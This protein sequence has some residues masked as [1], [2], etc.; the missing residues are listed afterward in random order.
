MGLKRYGGPPA[1]VAQAD[2]PG[3]DLPDACREG[4]CS[5]SGDSAKFADGQ[6]G[7]HGIRVT[8]MKFN[9]GQSL[10]A[11]LSDAARF[12]LTGSVHTESASGLERAVTNAVV[13]ALKDGQ[14]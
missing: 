8:S 2:L 12:S 1:A 7:N 10:Q 11:A 13:Q 3:A 5:D 6:T 9:A 4:T 14:N